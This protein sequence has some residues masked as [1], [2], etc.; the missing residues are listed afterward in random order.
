VLGSGVRGS[1]DARVFPSAC[2]STKTRPA[3]PFVCGELL[4]AQGVGA[5]RPTLHALRTESLWA[6]CEEKGVLWKYLEV[7]QSARIFLF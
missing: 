5:L 7:L 6:P 1:P 3:H 2:Q 4:L